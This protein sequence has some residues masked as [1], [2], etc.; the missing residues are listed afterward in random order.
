MPGYPNMSGLGNAAVSL[1]LSR[2]A[3]G[4]HGQIRTGGSSSG[5]GPAVL[6]SARPGSSQPP[7]HQLRAGE[8]SSGISVADAKRE[9]VAPSSM[10]QP[11]KMAKGTPISPPAE[12]KAV[13]VTAADQARGDGG[14][15]ETPTP[16]PDAG[17]TG[18]TGRPAG[19]EG[20]LVPR[21]SAAGERGMAQSLAAEP[22]AG[23]SLPGRERAPAAPV[24]TT[25]SPLVILSQLS[26]APPSVAAMAID[27]AEQAS[28]AARAE[29]RQH[30]EQQLPTI[31]APT[32][33]PAKPGPR[34]RKPPVEAAATPAEPIS[35]QVAGSPKTERTIPETTV[36]EVPPLSAPQPTRLPGPENGPTQDEQAQLAADAQEELESVDL[37]SEQVP[38]SLGP[39]P[40]VRMAGK[41]DP[42]QLD[43]TRESAD[44]QV[45]QA[46]AQATAGIG[47]DHGLGAIYPA[48][49]NERL[50]A[51]RRLTGAR[52]PSAGRSSQ[53]TPADIAAGLDQSLGPRFRQRVGAERDKYADGERHFDADSAQAHRDCE[54][55]IAQ[56]T[57]HAASEQRTE[58]QKATSDV[59]AYQQEWHAELEKT[60]QDYAKKATEAA[61]KQRAEIDTKRTEAEKKAAAQFDEAEAKAAEKTRAAKKKAD[62]EKSRKRE[63]SGGFWGWA[64][65]AAS[66]LIDGLKAALNAI[67]DGIRWAIKGLFKLAKEAAMLIIDAVRAV[68]VGLIKAFG[69]ILKGFISL[70]LIAFP[71]TA[72]RINA[73]IDRAVDFAVDKVNAAADK[74]KSAVASVLD[75]LATTIDK[76]LGLVQSLYN[77]ILT[78]IGMLIRGELRELIKRLGNV[79]KAAKDSPSHFEAAAYSVLLGNVHDPLSPEELGQAHIKPPPTAGT[80]RAGPP[81]ASAHPEA[82]SGPSLRPGGVGVD[83]VVAGAE[84]SPQ[85][86]NELIQATAGRSEVLIGESA[87]PDRTVAAMVA[88]AGG[89]RSESESENEGE[90]GEQAEVKYPDDGL[91]P[92][93]RAEVR[94]TLMKQGLAHWWE[95]NKV[96]VIVGAVAAILA[97]TALIFFSGG[98]ILAAIGPIMEI[99]GPLF[100]G[101]TIATIAG[102]VEKFVSKAWNGDIGG[103]ARS[104][105]DAL[106]N[107]AVELITWLTFKAGGAA[108]R[109]VKALTKAGSRLRT[110]L[111]A[112]KSTAGRLVARGAG[113][114][115]ERGKLLLKGI[116]GFVLKQYTRLREMG[117]ALLERLRFRGLRIISRDRFWVLQGLIN[118]WEDLGF[119]PKQELLADEEE[120]AAQQ[121]VRI[122]REPMRVSKRLGQKFERLAGEYEELRRYLNKPVLEPEDITPGNLR[123]ARRAAR[124]GTLPGPPRHPQV[125]V[126]RPRPLPGRALRHPRLDF[127]V[128]GDEI[129]SVKSF[130][131]SEVSGQLAHVN[132]VNDVIEHLREFKLKYAR[133]R[134]IPE[135]TVERLGLK[136]GKVA[137]KYILEIPP[138]TYPIPEAVL[139]EARTQGVIIRDTLGKVYP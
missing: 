77:G 132:D 97:L 91:S 15:G 110:A 115:I 98:T 31:P 8:I 83:E 101:A 113:F 118:P 79:V 21:E 128:E 60:E 122:G 51:R 9:A 61:K 90:Q 16:P 58:R 78:V 37:D 52:R 104:L 62:E 50:S 125:S 139:A 107:G 38:T 25:T 40:K 69:M 129:I 49:A 7:Q 81:S 45:A 46:K 35:A 85:V 17:Q 13:T 114:V 127:Y 117:A 94:W 26:Q 86:I 93:Q 138:Q 124:E 105:A 103:G 120:L 112:V 106:A 96:K 53:L 43:A 34:P 89:G 80:G 1:A 92:R 71:K 100:I 67:W 119:W 57:A 10:P 76:L 136:S 28:D 14:R 5:P 2:E 12:T 131:G 102:H 55:E 4:V 36:P 65:R 126:R 123:A 56:L 75:F 3:P 18:A 64:K 63:K 44:G 32:G 19:A 116:K 42:A 133:G 22:A 74:L 135:I 134:A 20:E 41:T 23:G 54:T 121:G 39:K 48:P 84:L 6:A 68:I 82:M 109:G 33:L 111:A 99:L 47:A 11:E 30:A 66:A 27:Q 137:G 24:I 73:Q 70:A 59:A 108:L 130:A 29:Q 72:R 88:E 87:S 95:E